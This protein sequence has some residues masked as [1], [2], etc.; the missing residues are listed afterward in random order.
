MDISWSPY[1]NHFNI[2]NIGNTLKDNRG[3]S[4]L[5]EYR[6]ARD[7]SESLYSRV[8]I[9]ITDQLS[10]FFSIEKNL[11]EKKNVETQ[12]GFTLEESCWTFNLY[13]S[14]SPDD[15]SITFLINLHGIGAF[16]TK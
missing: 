16:G 2:F 7:K 11:M 9:A 13:F 4:L 6:Y 12:A 5:T 8:N 15:Q 1:D 3:D 14:Q 10:G